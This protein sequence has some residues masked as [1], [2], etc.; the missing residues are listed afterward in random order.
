MRGIIR[1]MRLE[2]ASSIPPPPFTGVAGSV[3]IHCGLD[4]LSERS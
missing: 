1:T 2:P 4:F 3:L